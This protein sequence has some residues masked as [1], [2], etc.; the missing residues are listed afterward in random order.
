MTFKPPIVNTIEKCN[1]SHLRSFSEEKGNFR[2]VVAA[3]GLQRSLASLR[4]GTA[5]D[6]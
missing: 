4:K 6:K 1:K 2:I 3:R 5:K